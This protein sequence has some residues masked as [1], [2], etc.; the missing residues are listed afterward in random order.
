[1]LSYDIREL[2]RNAVRVDGELATDDP[3]WTE[4]DTLPAAPVRASGR[5]S[6]AGS[7]RFYWSGRIETTAKVAC[8]R[9][10]SAV[11][12]PVSEDVHA[13]FVDAGDEVADDPDTYP[14][15][16]RARSLDLRP[17]IRELWM[18]SA[19]EFLL[20]R[21]DCRGLCAHCGADLNAGPCA[22][23]P[24]DDERQSPLHA[25]GHDSP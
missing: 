22:C 11:A 5:L 8:R 10:L 25:A 9:C 14:I 24:A 23:D 2:E 12:T 17:A 21:E 13:L 4:G 1:M 15:P 20:C 6:S 16:P 18:L 19:P 3:I 7:G